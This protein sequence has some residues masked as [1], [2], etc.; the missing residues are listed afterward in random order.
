MA[1]NQKQWS[2]LFRVCLGIF[3]GAAFCMKWME[4][5]FISQGKPFTIIGL[6]ISYPSERIAEIMSGLDARVHTILSYHL[7]FDFAFM[8]GVY[9]GIASLCMMAAGR[10]THPIFRKVLVVIAALQLAGWLCD[11][12]E[13]KCLL[14]WLNGPVSQDLTLYHW[15][16][17][18]KWAIAL[19]GALVSIIVLL[20]K[21]KPK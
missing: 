19:S 9:P 10:V 17:R 15:V 13:N 18:A 1:L 8:V 16:V 4:S 3:I 5:D 6:E 14:E 7:Y 12:Y 20:V 2:N 21:R 11:I